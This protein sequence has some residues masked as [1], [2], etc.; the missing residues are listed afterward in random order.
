M[1]ILFSFP[2][3]NVHEL[4]YCQVR[5]VFCCLCLQCITVYAMLPTGQAGQTGTDKAVDVWAG[6]IT[7]KWTSL[8]AP[9]RAG[10]GQ[11]QTPGA[12][13]LQ[14]SVS[15]GPGPSSQTLTSSD[16]PD[17]GSA[18]RYGPAHHLK[19]PFS[20]ANLCPCPCPLHCRSGLCRR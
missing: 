6:E 18:G 10:Q 3:L 16:A 20:H 2:V 17:T 15:Q 1:Q 4:Y 12:L 5:V 8:V 9:K 14:P 7:K 13:P 19:H 11:G